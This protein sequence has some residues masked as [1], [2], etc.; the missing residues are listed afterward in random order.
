[1]SRPPRSLVTGCAGLIG[2]HLADEL[3]RRGHEV[4]GLDDL[5]GGLQSHVPAGVRFVAGS[6][7]DVPLVQSDIHLA[8]RFEQENLE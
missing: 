8:P 2:S 5:S 4:L 6:T 3:L 7:T 1:M